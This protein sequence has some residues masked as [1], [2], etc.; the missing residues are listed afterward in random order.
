M[1][2]D[3]A[4]HDQG[5]ITLWISQEATCAW[6]PPKVGK[7]GGQPVYSD[8][9]IETAFTLRLLFH[10]PLRQ[11]EGFLGCVLKLMGW[12]LPCPDHTTLSRRNATLEL[13]RLD[14]RGAQGPI[15]LIVDSTG[16]EVCGQ[17]EWHAKKHGEKH[18]KSWPKLHISV[19]DQGWIIASTVTDDR[20]QAPSQVPALLAQVDRQIERFIGAGIYD[21]EPVYAAVAGHSS[22][23]KVIIPPRKDAVLSAKAATSPTQRDRH[24]SE[25]QR[26]DQ[27]EWKR[28]SGYYNQSH[29][30]NAVSRYKRT[31]GGGLRAKRDDAQERAASLGCVLLNRLRELGRPQS[32]PLT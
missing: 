24:L 11:T 4:L 18:R 32:Y 8:L 5:D 13:S 25:M 17:G 28:T 15:D 9:A 29:A 19:D 7:R 30:E 14:N 31:F 16:L 1:A 6:T 3:R 21:Q 10:Q 2:Y 27:F 20:Q 23:A 26:T 12:S 22:G